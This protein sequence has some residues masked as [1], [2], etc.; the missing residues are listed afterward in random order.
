MPSSRAA[1]ASSPDD[2]QLA[3]SPAPTMTTSPPAGGAAVTAIVEVPVFPPADAVIDAP[4]TARAETSPLAVT[5]A[6]A[7]FDV[8][9]PKL[10][11]DPAGVAAAASCT[12]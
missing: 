1:V 8:A 9:H 12:L 7:L 2:A 6:T 11:A 3:M 5:V 10:V 4:P